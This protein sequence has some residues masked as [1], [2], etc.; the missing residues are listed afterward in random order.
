MQFYRHIENNN[1][2]DSIIRV[3][4][5]YLLGDYNQKKCTTVSSFH[6]KKDNSRYDARFVLK[7]ASFQDISHRKFGGNCFSLNWFY[8]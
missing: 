1:Y 4:A 6:F 2:Q 5:D 8:I 3:V 7:C